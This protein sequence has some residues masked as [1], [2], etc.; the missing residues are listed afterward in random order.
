MRPLAQ[1]PHLVDGRPDLGGRDAGHLDIQR[2]EAEL[3][4]LRFAADVA[5]PPARVRTL[6]ARTPSRR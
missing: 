6:S 3:L 4:P 5:R 1:P 2:H